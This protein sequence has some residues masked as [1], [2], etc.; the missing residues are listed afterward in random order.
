MRHGHESRGGEGFLTQANIGTQIEVMLH[1]D[2]SEFERKSRWYLHTV[3]GGTKLACISRP[4]GLYNQG[5]IWELCQEGHSE[6][7]FRN[8]SRLYSKVLVFCKDSKSSFN[9]CI[10]ASRH[11][12]SHRTFQIHIK[13]SMFI[14]KS[15][16]ILSCSCC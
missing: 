5:Q 10:Q 12:S 2:R 16:R 11:E 8:I 7:N 1:S 15:L 14:L 6:S 3:R 13:V 9:F 4:Y